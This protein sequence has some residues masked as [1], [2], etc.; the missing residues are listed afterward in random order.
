[1]MIGLLTNYCRI[2][3][4]VDTIHL[5]VIR[6]VLVVICVFLVIIFTDIMIGLIEK[7]LSFRR[8]KVQSVN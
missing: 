5:L 8:E 7:W 6:D 2:I 1:M 4:T 3:F